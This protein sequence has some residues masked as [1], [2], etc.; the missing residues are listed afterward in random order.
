MDQRE[1]NVKPA[2]LIRVAVRGQPA[3]CACMAAWLRGCVA[4][5]SPSMVACVVQGISVHDEQPF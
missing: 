5:W 2:W 1:L 4:A 3:W